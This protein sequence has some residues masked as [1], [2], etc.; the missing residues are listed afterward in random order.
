MPW[1][2]ESRPPA[3]KVV[4]QT[5]TP[6]RQISIGQ[7]KLLSVFKAFSREILVVDAVC[8]GGAKLINNSKVY[9]RKIS[10]VST[11][12]AVKFNS[13]HR[14][15]RIMADKSDRCLPNRREVV[16]QFAV[17]CHT[18]EENRKNKVKDFFTKDEQTRQ[19]FMIKTRQC[20]QLKSCCLET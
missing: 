6:H 2:A 14:I 4:S 7:A 12:K 10:S 13:F 1:T 20:I 3:C 9:L 19:P 5:T 11:L 8:S 17:P 15:W 16:V 18:H